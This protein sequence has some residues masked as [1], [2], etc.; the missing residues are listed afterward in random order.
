MPPWSLRPY[1]PEDRDQV[2]RICFL[3]GYMGEPVDWLWRDEQSFAD[4]FSGYWT[5]E[6]PESALVLE[7]EGRVCGYLLG[8]ADTAR[9]PSPARLLARHALGRLLVLRPGTAGVLWR[10]ALDLAL[11]ALAGRGGPPRPFTDRRWPAHLHIDLLPEAR[12]MG[13]GR[14]M[15]A[16]WLDQLRSRS[17]P[18]CH[19]ET[20]AENAPAVSFFASCGFQPHGQARL[21]PG[22]RD[23]DT[24]GRLHLLRMVKGL[25]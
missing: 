5:D 7:M 16:A 1:L 13:A 21:V 18:G 8:C 17:C 6:E 11:D 4:L 22:W 20:L 9:V 14:A 2:R 3:T 12:G 15:V 10:S 23:R 25:G 19:V 24:G